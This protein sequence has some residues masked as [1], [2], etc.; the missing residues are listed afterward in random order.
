VGTGFGVANRIGE[1]FA[2]NGG[3]ATAAE[4]RA[5]G[6]SDNQIRR[7]LRDG[8]LVA[9]RKGVYAIPQQ[10]AK[11]TGDDAG[12]QAL[13]LAAALAVTDAVC[14]G[15][16]ETAAIIHGL[17]LLQDVPPQAVI[18]TH[19]RLGHG[20]RTGRRGLEIRVADL[21]A[22]DVVMRYGVPVTSV[23]RTVVDLSRTGAFREGVV[24]A[25]SALHDGKTTRTGLE[26]AVAACPRWPGLRQARNVVAFS[27]GRS[28]SV[29]ESLARVIMREHGLPPP[30]LQVWI[31]DEYGARIARVDF[32]WPQ[33]RTIGEA[34]GAMKYDADRA[35]AGRQLDRDKKLRRAGYD[36]VHFG[37]QDIVHYP[38]EVIGEF[39]GSFRREQT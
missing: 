26:A 28:E 29:L 2:R 27:D 23:A 17:D 22:G 24:V 1:L 12:N 37:W 9:K 10:V 35:A 33:Y 34:D 7:Y 16:H 38:D 3:V 11:L 36:P 20:S 25:D 4:L 30:E 8:L 14:A 18:V 15:S 19:P 32:C 31:H 13:N 39:W 21:P 6:F 5:L